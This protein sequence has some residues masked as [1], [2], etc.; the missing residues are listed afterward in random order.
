M[1]Y[2][3][4]RNLKE[5]DCTIFYIGVYA[6]H[7]G[8]KTVILINLHTLTHAITSPSLSTSAETSTLGGVG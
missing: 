3:T 7:H 2:W 1:D 5:P 6:T 8:K 4:K